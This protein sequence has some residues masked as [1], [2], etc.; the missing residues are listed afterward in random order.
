MLSNPL[1]SP[2]ETKGDGSSRK[3]FFSET[4][5]KNSELC[6]TWSMFR[7]SG[8][9]F[10]SPTGLGHIE[11][12]SISISFKLIVT[13]NE[14][15]NTDFN[16]NLLHNHDFGRIFCERGMTVMATNSASKQCL[17]DF[18]NLLPHWIAPE[19]KICSVR[20]SKEKSSIICIYSAYCSVSLN[21]VG[22]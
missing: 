15:S 5:P 12:Q 10:S 2:A 16:G 22:E 13:S 20:I 21:S 11:K 1:L 14:L 9:R 17:T 6:P 8:H 18:V 19:S 7:I 4:V 3:G